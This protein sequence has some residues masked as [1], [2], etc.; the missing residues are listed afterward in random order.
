[1]SASFIVDVSRNKI[2][3][4][5]VMYTVG[6]CVPT[7]QIRHFSN[8]NALCFKIAVCFAIFIA[9]IVQIMFFW[10]LTP[11]SLVGEYEFFG[12]T[13]CFNFQG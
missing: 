4:R 1:M 6:L 8:F 9:G 10:V 11:C 13:C 3:C 12:E 5:S 2:T 7:K